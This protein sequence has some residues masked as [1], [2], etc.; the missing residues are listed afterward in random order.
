MIHSLK[1]NNVGYEEIMQAI[2]PYIDKKNMSKRSEQK[3]NTFI[4]ELI[5][6][7]EVEEQVK[8]E[9]DHNMAHAPMQS[10]PEHQ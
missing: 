7:K 9:P 8:Q 6:Q 1:T 10:P 2:H 3:L 4:T 5:K